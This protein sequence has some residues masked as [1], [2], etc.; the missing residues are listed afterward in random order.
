MVFLEAAR[1]EGARGV[2][3]S[4]EVVR[5]AGP[6]GVAVGGDVVDCAV[7]CQVDGKSRIGAVVARELGISEVDGCFLIHGE[8]GL[9]GLGV[10]GERTS[11]VFHSL[12]LVHHGLYPQ[13]ILSPL[14]TR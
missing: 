7:Q 12:A 5:A 10:G 6:V 14:M 11:R 4:E 9:R 13:V 2:A 3:A 8:F 1:E